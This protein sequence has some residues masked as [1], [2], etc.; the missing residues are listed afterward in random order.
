MYG[1][2][3]AAANWEYKYSSHLV[4]NGFMQGKVSPCVFWKPKTGVRCVVH[5]D[6]FTF[7]GTDY[8]LEKCSIMMKKEYEVK[9]IGKLGPDKGDDKSITILNRCVEWTPHGIQYEADPA[10]WR[11]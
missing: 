6:D 10:M 9:I 4:A 11:Y 7:A 2:Q 8:E 3:D 1:T 5:G